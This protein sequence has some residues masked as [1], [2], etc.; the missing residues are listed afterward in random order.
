VTLTQMPAR[1]A[2]QGCVPGQSGV[3]ITV[4]GSAIFVESYEDLLISRTRTKGLKTEQLNELEEIL[5]SA[6]QKSFLVKWHSLGEYCSYRLTFSRG[7]S[8][9]CA[10]DWLDSAESVPKS[11][12]DAVDWL[13][14]M[15]PHE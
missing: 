8:P 3:D 9:S 10:Y 1:L 14:K 15:A 11:I 13:R 5:Q 6:D 2:P 12:Y 7:Q 4:N